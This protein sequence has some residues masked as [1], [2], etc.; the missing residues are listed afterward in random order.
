MTSSSLVEQ[1]NGIG[2]APESDLADEKCAFAFDVEVDVSEVDIEESCGELKGLTMRIAIV[3]RKMLDSSDERDRQEQLMI[4]G[5]GVD[6]PAASVEEIMSFLLDSTCMGCENAQPVQS[7]LK[8]PRRWIL[9]EE[10]KDSEERAVEFKDVVIREFGMTIGDHPNAVSGPPV[11]I[12]WEEEKEEKQ[13]DIEEYEQRRQPRRNRRDLKL[14]LSDR[15]RILVKE[16]GHSF[17]EIKGAWKEALEIRAQRKETL[18]QSPIQSKWEEV[19]ESI[20][21]KFA[22]LISCSLLV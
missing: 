1:C 17:T 11:R 20:C 13:M 6:Q 3:P 22:R 14:S 9:G 7:I 4:P 5:R 16:K 8:A 12:D 10:E 15:H 21:R 18:S 2:E 19:Y